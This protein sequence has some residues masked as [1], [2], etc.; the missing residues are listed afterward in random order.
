MGKNVKWSKIVGGCNC[1]KANTYGF[2]EWA[3]HNPKVGSSSLPPLP[4]LSHI[5]QQFTKLRRIAGPPLFFVLPRFCRDSDVEAWVAHSD[6][7]R[8]NGC[9]EP[10]WSLRN[11]GCIAG[12]PCEDENE[13]RGKNR[14]PSM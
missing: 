3:I 13:G 4:N 9:E 5:L 1:S 2:A 14:K 12:L 10:E 7:L 6:A 11:G 8:R